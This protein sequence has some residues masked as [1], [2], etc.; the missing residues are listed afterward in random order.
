MS[1]LNEWIEWRVRVTGVLSLMR[2]MIQSPPRFDKKTDRKLLMDAIR[3][4]LARAPSTE[5]EPI[6]MIM[7]C[8]L[9]GGR[10]IDEDDFVTKPHRDHA[11]QKCGHVWRP[12]LVPTVGVQFLPGYKNKEKRT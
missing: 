9:C 1:S 4:A 11:C 7:F 8:P 3:D 12:A 6:P 2:D 5:P 10:H